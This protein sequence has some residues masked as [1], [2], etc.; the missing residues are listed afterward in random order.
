LY[1]GPT[2]SRPSD[3][4]PGH[5][6]DRP[7]ADGNAARLIAQAA[8]IRTRLNGGLRLSIEPPLLNRSKMGREF[9]FAGAI[10]MG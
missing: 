2:A 7:G 3:L 5:L 8:D 6:S 10:A 1:G 4:P 9:S